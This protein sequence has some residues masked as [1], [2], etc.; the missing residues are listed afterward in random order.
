VADD[1]LTIKLNG[2]IDAG[3]FA[4]A[5]RRFNK[6]VRALST[7]V[8][9]KAKITLDVEDLQV[10]STLVSTHIAAPEPQIVVGTVQ[11][12]HDTTQ[13]IARHLPLEGHTKSVQHWGRMIGDLP[14]LRSIESVRLESVLGEALLV[15]EE[16]QV[17][18]APV[19]LRYSMGA[20]R[21]RV[22][23]LSRR[24]GLRFVLYDLLNDTPVSCYLSVGQEELMRD[25]WGRLV[26]VH[27]N[28]GRDAEQWRPEVMR[29]ITDVTILKEVE[30]E[31]YLGLRGR[32]KVPAGG[33]EPEKRIR[34]MRD[35]EDSAL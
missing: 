11:S 28:V 8:D 6:F 14:R 25:A 10:G 31:S 3:D 1:T 22:E 32:W 15:R 30:P 2:T 19:T 7:E 12:Y 9:R 17:D 4:E 21:G 34:S 29:Q 20:L 5:M 27:G 18:K 23:T 16:I 35:D 33:L 26:L 13:L 24:R